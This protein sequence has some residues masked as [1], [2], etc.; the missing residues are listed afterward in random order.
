VKLTSEKVGVAL[1]SGEEEKANK[2]LENA[3]ERVRE[4]EALSVKEDKQDEKSE[5]IKIAADALTVEMK[6]AQEELEKTIDKP[7]Q[8][9]EVEEAMVESVQALDKKAGELSDKIGLQVE[10]LKYD[11][12]ITTALE[13]ASA[14]VEN[15][16]VKAIEVVIN[17]IDKIEIEISE[18][19]LVDAIEKKIKNAEDEVQDVQDSL[20]TA[21]A[22]EVDETIVDNEGSDDSTSD[23][24]ST[25]EE[26]E[27]EPTS[28]E[29]STTEEDTSVQDSK[30]I[31]VGVEASLT[32]ARDFLNQ[33]D[34]ISAIEII[35]ESVSLTKS[36]KDSV[37]IVAEPT[38]LEDVLESGEEVSS[39]VVDSEAAAVETV[40]EEES[41]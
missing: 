11:I 28:D 23:E 20:D 8:S 9:K 4:I 16:S 5:N 35:K 26:G 39:E 36:V 30:D 21:E 7:Q 17:R 19:D 2:Y 15:I 22:V 41:N 12:D 1:T 34:L 18:K 33:G 38:I 27:D 3:E 40:T 31:T 24:T 14:E 10:A 6:K 13:E 32:E 25:E 29:T 37:G